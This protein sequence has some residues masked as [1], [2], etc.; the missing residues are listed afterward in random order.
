MAVDVDTF[1]LNFPEF[2]EMADDSTGV[3]DVIERALRDAR[4]FCGQKQWGTRWQ[5]AVFVKAA[6][7]LALTPFGENMR[8][9]GKLSSPYAE[10]FASMQR[11]LHYRFALV[12][13]D[14]T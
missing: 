14:G 3:P 5:D 7:L 6:A 4:R 12:G 9:Q 2:E 10:M 11:Q 13:G 8:L 1:V